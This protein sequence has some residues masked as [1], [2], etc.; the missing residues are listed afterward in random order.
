MKLLTFPLV[1]LLFSC[2]ACGKKSSDVEQFG[3]DSK[4][5]V[6][7]NFKGLN[8]LKSIVDRENQS[9]KT[10]TVKFIAKDSI[11]DFMFIRELYPTEEI[12]SIE[13]YGAFGTQRVDSK[14]FPE[15][16]LY[17]LY[18]NHGRLARNRMNLM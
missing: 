9:K 5:E 3:S 14:N 11:D 10:T 17:I 8:L 13:I 18:F 7:Q 1:I 6:Q 12:D 16:S 15:N 2:L 4:T